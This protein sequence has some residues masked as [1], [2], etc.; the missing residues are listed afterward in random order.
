MSLFILKEF[1]GWEMFEMV[2]KYVYL[3][4]DYL[5]EYVNKVEIYGIFMEDL[6]N[7]LRLKFVV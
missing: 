6:K 3:N 5:L 7:E 4:I 2:K 1:G